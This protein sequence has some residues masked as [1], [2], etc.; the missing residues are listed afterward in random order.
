MSPTSGAAA[1]D[2]RYAAAAAAAESVWSMQPNAE[3]AGILGNVAPGS[4][5]DLGCGEG[6]NALWLASRGWTVTAVDYS[7]VGLETGRRRADTAGLRVHWVRADVTAWPVPEGT[8]LVLLA[9]LQLPAEQLVPILRRAADALAPGGRLV[10][11]GHDRDNLTRGVG[12]PQNPD[13]LHTV[14]DLRAGVGALVIERCEQVERAVE[15]A[16]RPAIDTVLIARRAG[17]R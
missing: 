11:V 6:R 14:A 2:A 17:D 13:I 16:D 9:Y 3:V 10:V 12:G 7:A 1:W 8:D 5:V 4:A 15:G